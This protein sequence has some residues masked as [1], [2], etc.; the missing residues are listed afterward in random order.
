F[1]KGGQ[2]LNFAVPVSHVARLLLRCAAEDQ[3]TRFPLVRHPAA[4]ACIERGQALFYRDDFD[5]AIREFNE[6]IRIDPKNATAY[7]H[8]GDA[9]KRKFDWDRAIQDYNQA[10]R[11]DPDEE[12]TYYCRGCVYEHL[13]DFWRARHKYEK[14]KDE[15][16]KAIQ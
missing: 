10:I 14:A 15:Y 3:L 11:L 4:V 8:R 5:N 16:E 6:A 13:G 2:N 12:D 7:K 1:L 9:W